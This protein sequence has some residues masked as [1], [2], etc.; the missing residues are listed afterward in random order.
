MCSAA[1][2]RSVTGWMTGRENSRPSAAASAVPATQS[3][4][5]SQ[6]RRDSV[7]STPARLRPSMNAPPPGVGTV[8][9]RTW[10]PSITRSSS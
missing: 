7:E 3:A 9:T 8:L 5:S 4:S 10:S 2:V 1:S 6:P